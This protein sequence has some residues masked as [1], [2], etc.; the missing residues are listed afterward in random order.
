MVDDEADGQFELIPA[1]AQA[2]AQAAAATERT[3]AKERSAVPFE[4]AP[5]LPVARVLVDVPLAHLDRPFDYLV[6]AKLHEQVVPGSRVK[7][8]FAGQDVDGY[9][10]ERVAES[11][12]AGRLAPLR[13]A[14]SAEPVLTPDVASLVGAVAE[15]YAGTRSDVLRL[16]VPPRHATTEK[17]ATAPAPPPTAPDAAAASARWGCYE[18]GAALVEA[19]R[20]GESPRAVWSA[21]PGE[22]WET[23][24]AAAAAVTHASGRG[25]VICVPDQRDLARLDGALTA[26][27]GPG[28]HVVAHRRDRSCRA[29][30]V[31]PGGVTG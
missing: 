8:R 10:V 3:T 9:V 25:A 6:P 18:G 30:P 17:K 31:V 19:L 2:R 16:A 13:R 7:V 22:E 20:A 4:P 26:A 1:L 23:A 14:V 28:Q 29:L 15:R 5:E 21:L 24:L 11:Q 12:H 27:L